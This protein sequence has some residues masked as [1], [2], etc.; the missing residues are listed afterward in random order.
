M[1]SPGLKTQASI[2]LSYSTRFQCRTRNDPVAI[3]VRLA[4]GPSIVNV[5]RSIRVEP[6]PSHVR[7]R[8]ELSLHVGSA[9]SLRRP[10]CY[11]PSVMPNLFDEFRAVV[12][13]LERARIP[14]AICGGIAM[15]IHARP[16]ATVDID[17]LAPVEDI[18]GLVEALRPQG[19]VRRERAPARLAKGAVV[20]HRLTKIVPG[21]PEVLSLDVIE[22]R[23][24]ATEDA[25]ETRATTPWE[26]QTVTVVSR[27]G[28]IGLKKLRGSPQDIA[29]IAALEELA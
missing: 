21:D 25:W 28:L 3:E 7:P 14:Y 16:R 2:S 26:A 27:A 4:R 10:P 1:A 11:A 8:G 15:S 18:E 22:V 5:A 9:P 20:M 19:F 29:D 6:R 24:G 23:P 17:L 12:G 13:A